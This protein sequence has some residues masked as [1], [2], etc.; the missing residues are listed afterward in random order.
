VLAATDTSKLLYKRGGCR[1]TGELP[2]CH[3]VLPGFVT[4]FYHQVLPSPGFTRF[5]TRFCHQVLSPGFVTRFCHQVLSPGFTVTRFYQVL[6]GFTRF[7]PG[8]RHQVFC[9][10]VFTY[11][12]RFTTRFTW[13][14]PGLP[15]HQV[16]QPGLP[17]TR[18][19][20]FSLRQFW[21]RSFRYQRN[22]PVENKPSAARIRLDWR[23]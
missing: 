7:S 2:V 17:V 18:F 8:F 22:R 13:T 21:L 3:Q 5:C 1:I 6:P 12:T 4:R 20:R 10:Q 15:C 11:L 16:Y 19:T 23:K 9:H 14:A